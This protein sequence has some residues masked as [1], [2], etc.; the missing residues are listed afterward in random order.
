MGRVPKG[1]GWAAVV[2]VVSRMAGAASVPTRRP[3]PPPFQVQ[4][5]CLIGE[6]FEE[7]SREV[8]GAVINIR[9]KGDKIA[10]WTQEAENQEG[11]LHIG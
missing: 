3:H 2:A 4:L 9:A 6:S 11:V 7:H 8:C 5:L 10:V 1:R